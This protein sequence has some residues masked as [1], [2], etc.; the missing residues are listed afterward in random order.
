[1]G[2]GRVGCGQVGSRDG[3]VVRALTSHYCSR[4]LI[5]GVE[6]ISVLTFLLAL[7]L[8]QRF[9]FSGFPVFLPL[10]NHISKFGNF[11]K[12]NKKKLI[13]KK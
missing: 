1:M 11:Q 8:A 2:V 13:K 7:I 5:H 6:A 4:G 12:K 10:Q 3:A 9:F